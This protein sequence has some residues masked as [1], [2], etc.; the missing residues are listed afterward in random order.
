MPSHLNVEI[1]AVCN[2]LD[3][4]RKL[5]KAQNAVFKGT[6]FQ[7]D[8]YFKCNSGRL[9][10]REGNIENH[11]IHYQRTD[12]AG[13]KDSVVSLYQPTNS[14]TL[15]NLL[16]DALGLLVVVQKQREIYFIKNVKFHIDTVD[17]LG[18]F[19]EIEAIQS[20]DKKT[21]EKLLEQCAHY[22]KLFD[23][24]KQELIDCSYSDMLIRKK[25]DNS[26]EF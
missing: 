25:E 5:L 16:C 6:D 19:V 7:T 3:R 11:L 20:A 8:T 2:N 9:K 1:K 23:I 13:P 21:R 10:L 22:L 14:K 15:K 4:L 17:G 24:K 12:Q 26:H 18:S